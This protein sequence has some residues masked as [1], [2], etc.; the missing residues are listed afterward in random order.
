MACLATVAAI[1]GI[2]TGGEGV[3][4]AQQDPAQD[5]SGPACVVSGDAIVNQETQIFSEA[6]GGTVLAQF[7]GAKTPLKATLF[8]KDTSA[9]RALINTAG[10]FRL[11]GY[12]NARAIQA[13]GVRD[14]AVSNHL[15]IS[16]AA[17]VTIIG[18]SPGK[19]LVQHSGTYRLS[20][21]LEAWVSCE[22][23]SFDQGP[24]PLYEVPREARGYVTTK[25]TLDLY[26]DAKGN[27]VNTL[28]IANQEEGLLLWGTQVRAGY[29][30]VTWRSTFYVDAWIKTSDVRALP[31]GEMV[32]Q[33]LRPPRSQPEQVRLTESVRTMRTPK[34]A[35]LFFGRGDTHP[36]IGS[37]E[38][39][40]EI[41][42]LETVIGWTTV[43]PKGLFVL[44][45]G[46]RAFWVKADGLGIAS[47]APKPPDP[48]PAQPGP[49][50]TPPQPKPP[51]NKPTK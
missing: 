11:E 40:T 51:E 50:A 16:A 45:H 20:R 24:A 35:T 26:D 43:L 39:D 46:N 48:K 32:D 28:Y 34:A 14:L 49:S 17:P 37:I 6:T 19:L 23:V 13:F 12:T 21:P 38:A 15:W 27:V 30:H 44:P 9:G 3:A 5:G 33:V 4:S 22:M 7:T 36:V 25:S 18:S 8:P 31:R 42:V 10:G 41:Y 1:A 47:P 2:I 29:V